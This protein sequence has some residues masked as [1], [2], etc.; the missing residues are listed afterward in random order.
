MIPTNFTLLDPWVSIV[1]QILT[2]GLC[3]LLLPMILDHLVNIF[4][5]ILCPFKVYSSDPIQ[6]HLSSIS[7]Q[8]VYIQDWEELTIN[9][10][11][12][13]LISSIHSVIL[14]SPVSRAVTGCLVF[15]S[16]P[17]LLRISSKA[18]KES[19]VYTNRYEMQRRHT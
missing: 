10:L 9:C 6:V 16:G 5:L 14:S 7:S 8:N 3:V 18:L 4:L 1:L 12:A 13:S 17:N 2:V 15:D 19:I 11:Y